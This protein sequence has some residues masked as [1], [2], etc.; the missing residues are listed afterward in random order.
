MPAFDPPPIP[1]AA[2]VARAGWVAGLVLAAV[3]GATLATAVTFWDAG[4]FLAAFH[5]WGIPHP[6]GTP[7]FVLLGRVATMLLSLAG[8]VLP[9]SL[10]SA[11]STV[12]AG[13]LTARLVARWTESAA[14]GVAGA[15]CAGATASVWLN[16]TETEVYAPS[17]CLAV[18]ALAVADRAARSSDG[19]GRDLVVLAYLFGVAVPL[20][21]SAIVAAPAVA[22]LAAGTVDGRLDRT[23]LALLGGFAVTA[24]GAG[25]VAPWVAVAGLVLLAAVAIAP[26]GGDHRRV[27]VRGLAA[28]AIGLT[29]VLVLLLRSRAGAALDQGHPTTWQALADVVARRQY[30]VAPLWP[31]QAPWWLQLANVAQWGDWQFALGLAGNVE[32]ST[33]RLV[34]TIAYGALGIVGARRLRS[35]QPRAWRATA[36]LLVAGSVG[37]AAMLNL[38]AGPSLGW[39]V[40]PDDA[41]HEARERDYFFVLAFWTWGAWAGIGATALGER[42]A[43]RWALTR[44][45][46]AW[47]AAGLAVAMLPIATNWRAATRRR[48][49]E[50]GLPRAFADALLASAPR[51]AVL[52]AIGDNDTYPVWYL[53]LA[54]HVRADVTPVTIPLLGAPW[55]RAELARRYAL[56]PSDADVTWRGVSA[57]LRAIADGTQRTGRA[58]ATTVGVPDSLRVAIGGAWT[59]RGMVWTWSSDA[60][61]AS[62]IDTLATARA[63]A[64][65]DTALLAPLRDGGDGVA[66]WTQT[67]LRCPASALTRV[68]EN[69]A[70]SLEGVCNPR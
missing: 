33:W 64:R 59:L 49:P 53:Q 1:R 48:R 44:R 42:L 24:A 35:A 6:P 62:R 25:S 46:I 63:A 22:L 8:P 52:L 15:V 29:P 14:A 9:G 17:L 66:Q 57:T 39:G 4:E 68:R 37:V 40:L 10:L 7:L 13:V 60:S 2:Y 38:K 28:L 47:R 19:G 45:S 41:P 69:A 36:L 16:A 67:L 18:V 43:A 31:R 34:A 32:P 3:Y 65:V 11:A 50:A 21:L 27:A 26:T 23:R 56:L 70:A 51:N 61:G 30:A 55:Y 12:V 5:T 20:H 54:E 58:L